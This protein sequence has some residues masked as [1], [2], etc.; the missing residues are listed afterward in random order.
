MATPVKFA[1]GSQEDIDSARSL[2]QRAIAANNEGDVEKVLARKTVHWIL[3][4]LTQALITAACKCET[5]FILFRLFDRL[6][7][8]QRNRFRTV[9]QL[10]ALLLNGT[11]EMLRMWLGSVDGLEGMIGSKFVEMGFQ[12]N[13]D[14]GFAV[15]HSVSVS[16]D[17]RNGLVTDGMITRAMQLPDGKMLE[18]LLSGLTPE[19]MAELLP[20]NAMKFAVDARRRSLAD[21]IAKST[22]IDALLAE[23][24]DLDCCFLCNTLSAQSAARQAVMRFNDLMDATVASPAIAPDAPAV[25]EKRGPVDDGKGQGDD[26]K[27]KARRTGE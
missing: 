20:V 21:T 3:A 13:S 22:S 15:L 4:V 18:G 1:P 9:A 5:E 8:A 7:F 6:N 11:V 2:L 17:K 10:H 24:T 25:G 16:N 19:R 27:G 12:R 26:G 14:F 23:L